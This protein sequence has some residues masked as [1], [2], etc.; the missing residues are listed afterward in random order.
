MRTEDIKNEI[1]ALN[2][3]EKLLLVEDIWDGIAES[4]AELPMHAWQKH[5]LDKRYQEYKSG[6][7]ELRDWQTVHEELRAK[8]K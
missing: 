5:E 6:K 8:Y 1:A 2:L 4:N 3:A 7:L